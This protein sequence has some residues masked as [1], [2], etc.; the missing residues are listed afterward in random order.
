MDALA[1]TVAAIVRETTVPRTSENPAKRES[2]CDSSSA[3]GRSA[4]PSAA[5]DVSRPSPPVVPSASDARAPAAGIERPRNS[6]AATANVTESTRNSVTAPTG[7]NAS[8]GVSDSWDVSV[9]TT[10]ERRAEDKTFAWQVGA[11]PWRENGRRMTGDPVR[12]LLDGSGRVR[13]IAARVRFGV[14]DVEPLFH[15]PSVRPD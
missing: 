11:R 15:R 13:Q 4:P 10:T 3:A 14:S 1:T 2:R 5:T 8:S 9:I 6:S 12:R 7:A